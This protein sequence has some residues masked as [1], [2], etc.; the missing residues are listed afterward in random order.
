MVL[1][2]EH[3]WRPPTVVAMGIF[4][5]AFSLGVLI[6]GT[7][8]ECRVA[9]LA[10]QGSRLVGFSSSLHS[11]FAPWGPPV[12]RVV[13]QL[14]F[15]GDSCTAQG[16]PSL[17]AYSLDFR[18]KLVRESLLRAIGW[19]AQH[20]P[21]QGLPLLLPFLH[22]PGPAGEALEDAETAPAPASFKPTSRAAASAAES[23]P[24]VGDSWRWAFLRTFTKRKDFLGTLLPFSSVMW[25]EGPPEVPLEEP[26][27][28]LPASGFGL[29]WGPPSDFLTADGLTLEQ[30]ERQQRQQGQQQ[31][32]QDGTPS[33][34][35]PEK[36][37]NESYDSSSAFPGID[38][39]TAE[40]ALL[41]RGS[42]RVPLSRKRI[43]LF[44][45]CSEEELI[46]VI[47]AA[48]LAGVSAL[49]VTDTP[50]KNYSV[51][52]LGHVL[53]PKPLMP[54]ASVPDTPLLQQM[55][56]HAAAAA[57]AAAPPLFVMLDALPSE[58]A[59][60]KAQQPVLFAALLSLPLWALLCFW[61]Q[62]ECRREGGR[63]T[64]ALHKLMLLPPSLKVPAAIVLAAYC[65]QCPEWTSTPSQYLV[66]ALMS[67]DTLF[68]T[69]FFAIVILISKGYLITRETLGRR[70]SLITSVM[71]KVFSLFLFRY[72]FRLPPCFVALKLFLR[73]FLS[74]FL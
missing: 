18:P 24:T 14:F 12:E 41:L 6:P 22:N 50:F 63:D 71:V 51:P 39:E 7:P 20:M 60:C 21:F 2:S 70:D 40:G 32:R 53:A 27:G 35:V 52:L 29:P 49:L 64:T 57:A 56:R 28:S 13:G 26:H 72:A 1:D 48:N 11:D 15:K 16:P 42:R 44:G 59:D 17:S 34:A 66:M 61:W 58:S 74:F 37:D 31:Q 55:K 8:V 36:G 73:L 46:A 9:F 19:L 67:L 4:V 5:L 38:L 47:E 23:K 69:S 54:V 43:W 45:K 25:A 33:A 10:S 30:Q 62:R 3:V 68:Q 65:L